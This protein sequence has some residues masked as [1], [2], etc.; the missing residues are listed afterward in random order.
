MS[1][2]TDH[3]AAIEAA[4]AAGPTEGPWERLRWINKTAD[5]EV[6]GYGWQFTADDYLL[7]LCTQTGDDEEVDA[8]A[9][10]IAACNPKAMRELLA[11]L[12]R[13]RAENE[14]LRRPL[15]DWEIQACASGAFSIFIRL[16]GELMRFARAIEAAHIKAA[17]AAKEK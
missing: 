14:A 15:Q 4:L 17:Q 3:I 7:P 13:L 12:A 2:M 11:E 10:F 1:D 6:T 5:G 16:N 8:N 9:A